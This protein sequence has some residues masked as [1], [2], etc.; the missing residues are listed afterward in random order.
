MQ[1]DVWTYRAG[2]GADPT[3]D[4]IGYHVEASDGSI[5]KIDRATTE[6]GASYIVVDTGPW[7]FGSRV[8]LPA[9]VIERVDPAE[10]RVFVDLTKEEI[11]AAPRVEDAFPGG[12]AGYENL[13][14]YYRGLAR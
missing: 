4:L 6:V 9:Y 13:G 3:R 11:T 5:G 10:R 1:I 2:I 14:D 12:E 7:I 8:V